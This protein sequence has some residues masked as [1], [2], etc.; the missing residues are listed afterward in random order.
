MPK[1]QEKKGPNLAFVS[2]RAES[3]K[4]VSAIEEREAEAQK[5]RAMG[6]RSAA[7]MSDGKPYTW[8]EMRK[9]E[10]RKSKAKVT[11]SS[12]D[13]VA[14]GNKKG[15][16]QAPKAKLHAVRQRPTHKMG[17][18][19][20]SRPSAA[21]PMVPRFDTLSPER[22]AAALAAKN[23][24]RKDAA[25][26]APATETA[27]AAPAPTTSR[28]DRVANQADR[29]NAKLKDAIESGKLP[30]KSDRTRMVAQY[31]A[32]LLEK[33]HGPARLFEHGWR[34]P[35]MMIFEGWMNL[36]P[37]ETRAAPEAPATD[38]TSQTDAPE[39]P[40]AEKS[41]EPETATAG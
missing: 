12:N 6:D 25:P 41:A 10:S 16:Q 2:R 27:E 34:G 31:A 33:A 8:G 37:E 32:H 24:V 19:Q 28:R 4:T 23:A 20:P 30:P 7:K 22:K 18:G 26:E 13:D 14:K 5:L 36:V 39:A 29:L 1:N 9:G 35:T 11:K 3:F 21:R 17:A 38:D 40:V 15:K